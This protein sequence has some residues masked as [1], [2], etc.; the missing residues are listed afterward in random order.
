MTYILYIIPTIWLWLRGIRWLWARLEGPDERVGIHYKPGWGPWSFLPVY[1]TTYLGGV[2][3]GYGV[4]S[5]SRAWYDRSETHTFARL[6]TH[7]LDALP[8]KGRHGVFTGP[9][10]WGSKSIR[11]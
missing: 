6:M 10:L 9:R 3:A 7:I 4:V 2:I 8:P 11:S 1:C 5:L